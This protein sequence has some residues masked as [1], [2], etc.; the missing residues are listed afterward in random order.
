MTARYDYMTLRFLAVCLLALSSCNEESPSL[1]SASA[2]VF[3]GVLDTSTEAVVALLDGPVDGPHNICSAVVIGPRVVLT[4]AHCVDDSTKKYHVRLGNAVATSTRS[5][6]AASVHVYPSYREPGDDQRAGYDLAIV[7]LTE[8]TGVT[9]VALASEDRIGAGEMVDVIGFGQSDPFDLS[10]TGIRY[11]AR[12]PVVTA[13]DRL[14]GTGTENRG[15]CGGDSGG[16]VLVEGALVGVIAFGVRPQCAPPGWATRIV[17][18]SA[19]IDSFVRGVPDDACARCPPPGHCPAT[20]PDAGP[21]AETS[22]SPRQEGEGER[23]CC[24]GRSTFSPLIG[25]LLVLL[26]VAPRR[27]RR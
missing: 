16:A 1:G 24:F 20:Q 22:P 14:L 8:D 25:L 17:P 10:S 15:F 11:S 13:C 21:T 9:P 6:N 4:A 27:R 26:L 7:L 2:P 5:I 23:G 19:W 12:V 3:G 18:Y